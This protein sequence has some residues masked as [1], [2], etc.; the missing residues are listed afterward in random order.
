MRSA[1]LCLTILLASVPGAIAAGLAERDVAD[2]AIRMGG[3]VT[4]EGH[5]GE[6]ADPAQLPAGDVRITGLDLTNTLIDPTDL[7]RLSGLTALRELYLPGPSWNPAS[8]SRLDAN[9]ELKNLAG[10]V[11][12]E[13]IYFSLH[14]L[15]TINVQDK[16]V[17]YWS[18]L[19]KL[20]EIRLSQCHVAAP[21]LAP[22]TDLRSL[23]VSYTVFNDAGMK[24]LQ[25]LKQI[26]RLNLRDTLITDEGLQSIEGLTNLEELDLYGTKITDAGIARLRKLTGLTK[27][28]L[29][30]ADVSDESAATIASF[31]HLRELNLYRSRMTN[32]GLA[33][34]ATLKDLVDLDVRYSRVTGSGV[35]S[36]RAAIP[37]CKVEY[38]GAAASAATGAAHPQG[39]GDQAVADWARKL[40]GKVELANGKVKS[41]SLRSAHVGDAQL[42][43]LRGLKEIQSLD[44]TATEIGDLGLASVASITSLRE[45]ILNNTTV[46]DTGLRQLGEL[47]NLRRIGLEGTLGARRRLSSPQGAASHGCGP[48]QRAS[49]RRWIA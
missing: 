8:G 1:A 25:N 38:V 48:D 42:A 35:E 40:G 31:T 4:I 20:R 45:L 10:L 24:T 22:F 12:L 28:N 49:Q 27:L 16:G 23:D 3:R 26:R 13:R 29:L 41:I 36:L 37:R 15:P 21:N 11:N 5:A 9:E 34:L 19:T 14:F 7:R 39:T 33:R 17:A 47:H 2:W 43:D 18:G 46:S 30:G 44:L 6:L 32:S